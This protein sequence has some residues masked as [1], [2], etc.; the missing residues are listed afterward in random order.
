MAKKS[1]KGAKKTANSINGDSEPP[2]EKEPETSEEAS[3]PAKGKKDSPKAGTKREAQKNGPEETSNNDDSKPSSA[4][5]KKTDS[6]ASLTDGPALRVRPK[7][8]RER[9]AKTIQ[10]A[11]SNSVPKSA[12]KKSSKGKGSAAKKTVKKTPTKT[13]KDY[14]VEK[15]I[16]SRENKKG[17]KEYLVRWKGYG[18]KDD[19]WEPE[20]NLKCP[21]L[22]AEFNKDKD[23]N[24]EE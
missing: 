10:P 20:S 6:A 21:T 2:V 1:R 19:T 24:T 18:A 13:K 12:S 16:E 17:K 11:A 14:E 15:I 7:Q 8:L 5:K 9:P 23:G 4:K 22:L 3:K